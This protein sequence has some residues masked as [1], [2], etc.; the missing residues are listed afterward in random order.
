MGTQ[1]S[2]IFF[3]VTF[4]LQTL[5]ASVFS[6]STFNSS[7]Q[8]FLLLLLSFCLFRSTATAHGVSQAEGPIGAVATSLNPSHSHTGSKSHLQPTPQLIATQGC[9]TH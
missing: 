9:L 2:T 5:H 3:K 8:F 7:N 6:H 1:S 4:Q